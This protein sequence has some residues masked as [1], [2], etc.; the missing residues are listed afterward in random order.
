MTRNLWGELV[1]QHGAVSLQRVLVDVS[2]GR[3]LVLCQAEE[4]LSAQTVAAIQQAL[5]QAAPEAKRV[6]IRVRYPAL[7]QAFAQRG[8]HQQL[9]LQLLSG[10]MASSL[11]F[12]EQAIWQVKDEV[13]TLTVPDD[14]AKMFLENSG[15][16]GALSWAIRQCFGL[17]MQVRLVSG[18][19][20]D[21]AAYQRQQQAAQERLQEKIK[22][23]EVTAP[24]ASAKPKPGAVIYGRSFSD[25]ILPISELREDSGRVGVQCEVMQQEWRELRGGKMLWTFDVTDYTGSITCKLFAEPEERPRLEDMVKDGMTLKIRGECQYDRFQREVVLGVRDMVLDEKRSREDHAE[26]KRVELH[27][28][29]QM[30]MMDSVAPAAEAVKLAAR[31]GHPAVAITDHGVVQGFPDAYEAAAK[32]KNPPKVIYG[33]EG[34]LIE[35]TPQIV[36]APTG[37]VDQPMVVVDIETTGLDPK[38]CRI[39]EIGAVK[40]AGGKVVDRYGSLVNPG[41]PISDEITKLTGITNDMVS[42]APG[43]AEAMGGFLDFAGDLALVAHNASFDF[44]F[45]R[46]AAKRLGRPITAPVLDTLMLSRSAFP[47][48]GRHS[49]GALVKKFNI[50]LDNHHRAVDDAEATAHVLFKLLEA[51]A[52]KNVADLAGINGAFD[53]VNARQ[54]S[55]HIILLAQNQEGLMNLYRMISAAHLEHYYKRPRIPRGLIKSMRKGIVVGSACE[56]GELFRAMVRGE[57][58][59]TL[60]K[61]AAFYDYLEIQPIGNNAFMIRNGTAKNEEELRNYN[62]R[63]VELGRKL[64]KMVVATG[65]VHFLEPR[66]EQFRRILMAGQGFDDADQ[67]APLYFRTTE[68]MLDEFAYLGEETAYE[69]VVENPNKIAST[70]EVLEPIPHENSYPEIPG[71]EEEITQLSWDKAHKL[72]GEQL[73]EIVQKRVEKELNSIVGHGFA[74]L[75]LIAHKLVTKSLSDG[76]LVGSRGSVGSS[77]VAT[78][79]D[80]TEVNPLPAHYRCAK[81]CHSDFGPEPL[82]YGDICGVDLPEKNCP[83]C[84]EPLV[85][86]GYNIP[87]EVFL[88]FD[89]DKVPDIDLNFSGE[90]QPVAHAYTEE[91]F[92]K[93]KVFRAGTISTIADKTAYGYVVRY[94]EERGITASRAEIDRLVRG[95]AGVKRT[96]GQHPGGIIVVP[97]KTDIHEYTPVQHPA[98]M[99]DSDTVTTHFDFN[100]LHDRLLKLDILGHDAPTSIRMLKD[101]TGVDPKDVPLTDP[102]VMSLFV[103]TEALGLTP[104]QLGSPVGT[105]GIPE[106]GTSFVRQM[107]V[108]TK[109]SSMSDLLRISGLSHG[110]D[111]WTGNAQELIRS[112]TSTLEDGIICTRDD[113]MNRLIAWGVPSKLSFFT[114]ESVRKGKGL[115]PEMEE[116]MREHNVPEW[117]IDACK[118]IKYLFPKAHAAAYDIMSLRIAYFKVYY[119]EAYYASYFTIHNA[120]FDAAVILQG[121]GAVR[122]AMA[123]LNALGKEINAKQKTNMNTFEVALE[124]MMRGYKFLPVSRDESEAMRF[125]PRQGAVLPPFGALSGVGANAAQAIVQARQEQEFISVEDLRLRSRCGKSVCETLRAF[126]CLEGLPE[127]SQL[128]LFSMGGF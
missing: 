125:L 14:T 36:T 1:A 52:A 27:L 42:D 61:I 22:A 7:A 90:Y 54:D 86:D 3:Y 18:G 41:V 94:L 55:Y 23:I 24:G 37:P 50:R 15:A 92:G 91:L 32:L 45:L 44:S 127:T 38:R 96:T 51:V 108:E 74:V 20:L 4:P 66:D 60:L 64:N 43:E 82:G 119:P 49:L 63:I 112:G 87:F 81:C 103:S 46:P 71:A 95:C 88:G 17:L 40:V 48:F 99:V 19:G 2:R 84:G 59:A 25:A 105:F 121:E 104:E 123:D 97:H 122:K 5:A 67:Q 83:V 102:K 47:A 35:D 77:L 28:H 101:F 118:K 69:V 85:R 70:V 110:T 62:R 16:A 33:V 98:D 109:P 100:S 79:T 26:H 39:I 128:D 58:E 107:L 8:E 76:Y 113:I 111:V 124:M 57:D 126:G 73:P 116:A 93:G 56:A 106:F 6:Q 29:T 114:M 30:S 78:L 10:R 13:L 72:Y 120:D 68:E 31:F 34:Y 21:E 12:L 75:Y 53:K 115:K 117:Y 9:P 11:P 65:D 89:G 80:I